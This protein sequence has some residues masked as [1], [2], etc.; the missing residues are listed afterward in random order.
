M[1]R[2]ARSRLY[3][4]GSTGYLALVHESL[5]VE[6]EGARPCTTW[7]VQTISRPSPLSCSGFRSSFCAGLPGYGT[8]SSIITPDANQ[9]TNQ[10][11]SSIWA[12]I[13]GRLRASMTPEQTPDS[14]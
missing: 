13:W 7:G 10:S 2:A 1:L 9:S 3:Y 12:L 8:R 4:Q 14:P 11:F 5:S 6:A